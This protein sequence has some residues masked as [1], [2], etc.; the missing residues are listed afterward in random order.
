MTGEDV[1]KEAAQ[2]FVVGLFVENEVT[3]VVHVV[4]HLGGKVHAERLEGVLEGRET[5]KSHFDFRFHNFVVFAFF[6]C[7]VETLPRKF[8]AHEV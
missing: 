7:G 1:S 5:K 8:P 3:T 2:V 6:R 4:H